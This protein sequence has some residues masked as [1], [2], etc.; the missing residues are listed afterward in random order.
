MLLVSC[1]TNPSLQSYFVDN[2]ESAS[3]ISQDI[4]ITMLKIDASKLDTDQKEAYNSV[5][6]LNFLGYKSNGNENDENLKAEL[7]KVKAILS[8]EK[9][10]DLLEFSDKGNK[11]VV[12]YIGT[13]DEADEVVIFGS[14]KEMGFGI[15]RILGDEMNPEK[16]STLAGV[17]Q[18]SNVDG[19]QIKEMMDFF[20]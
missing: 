20:K 14:S 10:N 2:Q 15:V 6:R 12:K 18:T 4:P 8:Q 9:Y 11:V 1:D 7:T 13:D 19:E 5:K 16:M 3:F 17:L